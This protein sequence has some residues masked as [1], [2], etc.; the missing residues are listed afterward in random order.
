MELVVSDNEMPDRT[1]PETVETMTGK[2]ITGRCVENT[3]TIR[4]KAVKSRKQR[5]SSRNRKR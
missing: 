4:R 3:G 5:R 1:R 2:T